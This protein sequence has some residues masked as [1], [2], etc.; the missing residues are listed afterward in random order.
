[1]LNDL[2]TLSY[3]NNLVY[4]LQALDSTHRQAVAA[5]IHKQATAQEGTTQFITSTFYP[6]NVKVAAQCYGVYCKDK[7]SHIQ[8][9]ER[10]E[11]LGFIR[12]IAQ[13]KA[14]DGQD[15]DTDQHAVRTP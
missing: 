10:R 7:V 5:L 3:R 8:L 13:A 9:L 12:D 4:F 1:M 15:V 11:A 6:E 14:A 2:A